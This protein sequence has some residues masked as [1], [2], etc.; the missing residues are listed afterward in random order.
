ML[1]LPEIS[2]ST[3]GLIFPG[4]MSHGSNSTSQ[5]SKSIIDQIHAS[6]TRGITLDASTPD[7][8]PRALTR[9]ARRDLAASLRRRELEFTGLDLWI[10]PE[11]FADPTH[12]HRAINAL[13]QAATLTVELATLVAGRS[14]PVLSIVL[15]EEMNPTDR[16]AIGAIAQST[17]ALIA[18]HQP[19]SS[20]SSE[21]TSESSPEPSQPTPGIDI[22]IDPVMILLTGNSPGKAI[23]QASAHASTHLASVR[24]SDLNSMGRCPVGAPG[25]KLDLQS[26]AGALLVAGKEWITLDLR[27][28]PDPIAATTQ[29]HQAWSNALSF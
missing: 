22:G 15:P 27:A 29:A 13:S 8:R 4:S 10:P 6:N 9:S 1:G 2:I 20:A 11:H 14:Q 7:F 28:L 23:T 21:S 16:A 26:Y 25:S 17:G 18:D 3:A 19:Q 12:T 24:L 5:S